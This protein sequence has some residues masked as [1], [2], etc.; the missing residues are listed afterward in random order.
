VSEWR[1]WVETRNEL[2]EA[3]VR[4][5]TE[6]AEK[7]V[8]PITATWAWRALR[9]LHVP[10]AGIRPLMLAMPG[11]KTTWCTGCDETWPC[12]VTQLLDEAARETAAVV[13]GK[14]HPVG[15]GCNAPYPCGREGESDVAT[16]A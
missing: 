14:G 6:M 2:A 5:R 11:V 15:C 4:A 12:A 13:E 3:I 16:E 10:T 1:P 8:D 7:P 9:K